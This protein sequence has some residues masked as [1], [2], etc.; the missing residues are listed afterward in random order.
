MKLTKAQWY[1]NAQAAVV[2][3]LDDLSYGYLD[4]MGTGLSPANDWGY[5]C[6][7]ENSIFRYFETQLLARFPEIRYTVFV[8]FGKHAIGMVDSGHT[9]HAGD[10]Y[11]SEEFG[12]LLRHIVD[13]GNEIAYHGHH[14]GRRNPTVDPRTWR[15][16][17]RDYTPEAYRELVRADVTRIRGELGIEVRGGR[18]PAYL[19]GPALA[20]AIGS[21]LFRWWSFDFTPYESPLGYRDR[22]LAMP[23]NISGD[24]F[25]RRPGQLR[26]LVRHWH[27]ERA[28]AR[29]VEQRSVI[30]VA[31]H[32]LSSRTDGRRQSPNVFDDLGS[33][34]R[35]FGLLRGMPLWYA[36]CSEIARYRE[37][38]DHMELA[39]QAD[40]SVELT[41][42]GSEPQPSVTL[43]GP[44]RAL[45]EVRTGVLHRGQYRAGVWVFNNIGPGH[46]RVAG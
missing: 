7:R 21:G 14:H 6:R 45:V 13:T 29:L 35:I 40:G 42:C 8:P 17:D 38:Y 31:E 23:S 11:E 24:E 3:T 5:G 36:T 15:E 26:T 46:Y 25:R 4:P 44:E 9:G 41:Y 22:V 32:F 12:R 30:S 34:E 27:V 1:N 19:T 10:I 16:E 28:L 2:L 20:E 18:S 43:T 33:L 37:C 39:P